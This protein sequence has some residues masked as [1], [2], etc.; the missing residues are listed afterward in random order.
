MGLG[1]VAVNE[2]AVGV[3]FDGSCSEQLTI[4]GV[5]AMNKTFMY[6]MGLPHQ[7][8]PLALS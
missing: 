1:V 7:G 5:K 8:S 6:F 2:S 4:S 3:L